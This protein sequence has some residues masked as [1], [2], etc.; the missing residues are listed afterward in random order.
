MLKYIIVTIIGFTSIVF[1]TKELTYIAI[2][3][4]DTVSS[5]LEALGEDLSDTKPK[6]NS[7]SSAQIGEDII[8][9]GF[10]KRDGLKKSRRQSKHFVCTSCHNLEREDP[11]LSLSDPQARLDYVIGK[12]IPFLQGTTMYGAVNRTS[13]YNDD[14]YKKYGDL[15]E[16]DDLNLNAQ[17]VATIESALNSSTDQNDAVSLIRSKYLQGSPATFLKP[18]EDRKVGTGLPGDID[19]GKKL[20]DSSCLHC[21]YQQRYSFLHL[22]DNKL[23]FRYLNNGDQQL[24]DLRSYI[25]HRALQ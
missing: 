20:Y 4:D 13:F 19:N 22:D 2:D 16:P 9:N 24:A 15:I 1:G 3:G 5:V 21:H 8:R 6:L 12:G 23:S 10:S 14:Y 18:P 7:A 25:R 17:E 11:D